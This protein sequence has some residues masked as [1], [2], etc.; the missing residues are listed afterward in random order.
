MI[1]NRGKEEGAAAEEEGDGT[2]DAETG[3]GKS[4]VRY[5][6]KDLIT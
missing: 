5:F 6:K 1:G 3:S 2:G 4:I